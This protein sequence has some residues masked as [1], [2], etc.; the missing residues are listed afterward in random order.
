MEKKFGTKE[1]VIVLAILI[2]LGLLINTISPVSFNKSSN[3]TSVSSSQV[4]PC[5]EQ[6]PLSALITI[7]NEK[8][9]ENSCLFLG[10]GSIF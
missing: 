1:K 10:C 5:K 3:K 6:D 4:N 2:I 8:Q 9:N 7:N